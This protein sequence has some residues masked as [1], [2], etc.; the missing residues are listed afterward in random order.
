MSTEQSKVKK[1]HHQEAHP[2]LVYILKAHFFVKQFFEDVL[3]NNQIQFSKRG[4]KDYYNDFIEYVTEEMDVPP[5]KVPS[6]KVWRKIWKQKYPHIVI[7]ARKNVD[8]KDRVRVNLKALGEVGTRSEKQHLSAVRDEYEKSINVERTYYRLARSFAAEH[9][10]VMLS[11]I[12][13][14]VASQ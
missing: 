5:N 2:R 3:L 10:E 4:I 12:T 8:T 9:P 6:Q 1:Y 14:G 13:D 11:F 7:R